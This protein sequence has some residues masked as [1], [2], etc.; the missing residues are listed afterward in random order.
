MHDVGFGVAQQIDF[1]VVDMDTVRGEGPAAEDTEIAPALD[2][3]LPVLALAL[4]YV[5]RCLR[6]MHMKAGVKIRS[7]FAAARQRFVTQRKGGVQTKE[8]AE[9]TISGSLAVLKKRAILLD[10]LRGNIGAVAVGDLIAKAAAQ[11][12]LNRR[13][14]RCE[15]NCPATAPGLA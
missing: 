10:P 1:A 3:A 13:R 15:T 11:A 7:H 12:G 9:L 6:G 2:D 4:I 5:G 14:R 8:A